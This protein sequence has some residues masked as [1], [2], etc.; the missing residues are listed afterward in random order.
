MEHNKCDFSNPL[1]RMVRVNGADIQQWRQIQITVFRNETI[2]QHIPD[3]KGG[4]R[5]FRKGGPSR[6]FPFPFFSPFLPLPLHLE[7]GPL[8]PARGSRGA[9]KAPPAG[10]GA[11]PN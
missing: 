4:S 7:V 2:K 5:N 9:L 3:A 10:S 8:K 1:E 6:S 11:E